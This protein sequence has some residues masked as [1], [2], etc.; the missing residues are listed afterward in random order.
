MK[1]GVTGTR[2]GLTDA[3][4]HEIL[5]L[6]LYGKEMW[7]EVD[8]LHH[9]DCIGVDNEFHWLAY[10]KGIKIVIHPPRLGQYRAWSHHQCCGLDTYIHLPKAYLDRNHD[11][12]DTSDFLVA[13][14]GQQGE[15]LRSGT[16]ACV[17]Y[18][19]KQHKTIFIILPDGSK[20]VEINSV[21]PR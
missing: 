16:W 7:K 13:C 19:R 18:A 10:N 4:K 1:V 11:I 12:V 17:R 2:K 9:G 14:P 15:V 3:Q 21:D 5:C 8:E 6:S 20:R